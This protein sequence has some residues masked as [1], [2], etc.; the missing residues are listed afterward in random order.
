MLEVKNLKK[1][2]GKRQVLSNVNFTVNK[3]ESLGLLGPNGAGKTSLLKLICGL[4]KPSDGRITFYN[5]APDHIATIFED[6][7]FLGHIS[8]VRNIDL[9]M[10]IVA[11]TKSIDWNKIFVKYGLEHS[12]N[13][14]YKF[15]SSGMK[16][17]L[18]L[19]SIFISEH[20]SFYILDE[21]TNGLDIDSIIVFNLQI[22]ELTERKD[23]TFIISSH[24]A[25]ELEKI[26]DRFIIING[27]KILADITK[28]EVL[29]SYG[30]LE[31]AYISIIS[32]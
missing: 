28:N 31:A 23:R 22:I 17:K 15:Y 7:R 4:L 8:A 12:K 11:D 26:C 14:K 6:Q 21:P 3:G 2:Y 13:T 25:D 18:D 5:I 19:M 9:F 32:K 10:Q 20:K 30:K 29:Q 16:R 1:E 24:H 27:G